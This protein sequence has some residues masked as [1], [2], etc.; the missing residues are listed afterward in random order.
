[1]QHVHV[2]RACEATVK[3]RDITARS[4]SRVIETWNIN[5]HVNGKSAS[6][7]ETEVQN[8][9]LMKL[10]AQHRTREARCPRSR[11]LQQLHAVG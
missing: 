2:D 7:A 3:L 9:I 6:S 1:M 8:R 4:G 10:R 5:A 11:L